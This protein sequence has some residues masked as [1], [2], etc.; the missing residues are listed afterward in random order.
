M[1]DPQRVATLWASMACYRDSFTLPFLQFFYNSHIIYIYFAHNLKMTCNISE[2]K[3]KWNLIYFKNAF[4]ALF[5]SK[6]VMIFEKLTVHATSEF[7]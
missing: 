2:L 5:F 3:I 4:E 7:T 1:W 6:S